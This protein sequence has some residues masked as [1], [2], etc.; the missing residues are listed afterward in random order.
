MAILCSGGCRMQGKEEMRQEGNAGQVHSLISRNSRAFKGQPAQRCGFQTEAHSLC[1][2]SQI[3]LPS[4]SAAQQQQPTVTEHTLFKLQ[5]LMCI[6]WSPPLHEEATIITMLYMWNRRP[7]L[8]WNTWFPT[9]LTTFTWQCWSPGQAAPKYPTMAHWLCLILNYVINSQCKK[10]TST[11]SC[12]RECRKHTSPVQ[13]VLA[14]AGLARHPYHQSYE[15]QAKKPTQTLVAP[16]L[17]YYTSPTVRS[18][19]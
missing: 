9:A 17:I 18:P 6:T 7:R 4:I 15:I 19:H 2:P 1:L 13:G 14:P 5:K 3:L 10:G 12:L 11:P 8:T 16:L